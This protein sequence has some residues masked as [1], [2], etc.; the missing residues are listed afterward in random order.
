MKA[1]KTKNLLQS[2]FQ[3]TEIRFGKKNGINIPNCE[4]TLS[5]IREISMDFILCEVVDE[6]E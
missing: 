6:I 4:R 3:I 1:S 2:G 5:D